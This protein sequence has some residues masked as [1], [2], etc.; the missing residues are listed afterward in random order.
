M[1]VRLESCEQFILIRAEVAK[2]LF[3]MMDAGGRNETNLELSFRKRELRA[4]YIHSQVS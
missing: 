3:R 2:Y 1:Y 4:H